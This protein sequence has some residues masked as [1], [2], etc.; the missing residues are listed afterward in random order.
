MLMK[1]LVGGFFV[2]VVFFVENEQFSVTTSE[3]DRCQ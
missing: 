2:V 3:G 1:N